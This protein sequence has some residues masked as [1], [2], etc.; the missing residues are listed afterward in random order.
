MSSAPSQKHPPILLTG[1]TTIVTV[2]VLESH[3]RALPH[4]V[5]GSAGT[6]DAVQEVLAAIWDD[7]LPPTPT[8]S[9][10]RIS[11]SYAPR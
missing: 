8:T 10:A 2:D 1:T 6:D 7:A 5:H 11:S 3:P 4:L 9:G